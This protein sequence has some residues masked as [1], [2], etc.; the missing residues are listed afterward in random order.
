M[1]ITACLCIENSF[2]YFFL[3]YAG[4]YK[5]LLGCFVPPC[6]SQTEDNGFVVVVVTEHGIK[7]DT[8]QLAFD[9]KYE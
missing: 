8:F 4:C 3:I 1:V 5:V 7:S 9:L 2:F 6:L